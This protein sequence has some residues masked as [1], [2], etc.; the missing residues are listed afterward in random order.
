MQNEVIMK[1]QQGQTII[2]AVVALATLMIIIT[3]IAV[4]MMNG[5]YNSQFIKSQ[6]EANKY[7]QEAIEVVRNTQKN[8]LKTF[9]S[10]IDAAV[11]FCLNDQGTIYSTGCTAD[12]VNTAG[13]YARTIE[14]SPNAS[15]CLNATTSA[16]LQVTVDVKWSSTKCPANDTFCHESKLVTCMPYKY[17]ESNP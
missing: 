14:F 5:L 4:V 12:T 10:Y 16:D 3:A 9:K 1:K 8:D 11:L 15:E 6:N 13:T 17:P 7:A 2:E